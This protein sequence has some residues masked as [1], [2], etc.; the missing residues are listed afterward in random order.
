MSIPFTGSAVVDTDKKSD[1]QTGS[2][3]PKASPS[4]AKSE[5]EY[6]RL[7]R[8]IAQVKRLHA[9]VTAH[10]HDARE[11]ALRIGEVLTGVKGSLRHGEWL[12]WL[13][14]NLPEITPRTAQSYMRVWT[15]RD[16]L[17][18]ETDSYLVENLTAALAA[19]S[20]HQQADPE[21]DHDATNDQPVSG[22]GER[23]RKRELLR[24]L[25]ADFVA[26][27][28]TEDVAVLELLAERLPEWRTG[29]LEATRHEID[30]VP[31]GAPNQEPQP[32][33]A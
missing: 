10:A 27:L 17:K 32:F 31:S 14:A 15:N 5:N 23:S 33:A 13:T 22:S 16:L 28:E 21:A 30:G 12:P 20:R 1:V 7:G 3:P 19:I 6:P 2:Q 18:N 25:D 26:G 11:K 24:D 9:A 29:L 4:T 8:K